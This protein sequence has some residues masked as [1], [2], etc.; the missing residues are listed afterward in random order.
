MRNPDEGVQKLI[1]PSWHVK[2]AT[3]MWQTLRCNSQI[4]P[5]TQYQFKTFPP[6]LCSDKPRI[7]KTASSKQLFQS[8]IGKVTTLRCSADAEPLANFTWFKDGQRIVH[9]VNSAHNMSTLTLRPNTA[10]DF[11]SYSCRATNIK[12]AAWYHMRIF[13]ICK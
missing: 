3:R 4:N 1:I 6:Y 9:G 13:Q 12:G 8:W 5:K 11:G 10:G 7:N 2:T